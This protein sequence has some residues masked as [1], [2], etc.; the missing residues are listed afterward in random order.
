MSNTR[1]IT[2]EIHSKS[3]E[4]NPLN[5]PVNR[6]FMVYLPPGYFES[7][8]TRYPVIYLLHGYGQDLS[9]L[10]VGSKEYTKKT[11]PFLFRLIAWKVF[12]KRP[13]YEDFDRLI[14]N[15][16]IPPFILVQPECSLKIPDINGALKDNGLPAMKGAFYL[17]SPYTG[18]YSDFIFDELIDYVD[19][20]YRTF[21]D[22]E[23]RALMGGSM[24]G[25][26]TLYG[27]LTHP[28]K[29]SVGVALS[30]LI[31]FLDLLDQKMVV[32]I[33]KLLY[34]KKKA[35]DLGAKEMEDILDTSDLIFCG[36]DR[37]IPSIKRGLNGSIVEMD[38]S[39]KKK[40]LEYDIIEL[41]K[42]SPDPFQNIKLLINCEKTDEYGFPE[43]IEKLDLILTEMGVKHETDIY[44]NKLAE[45]FSPHMVGIG[46][47]LYSGILYCLKNMLFNCRFD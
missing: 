33:Y 10:L 17:N 27:C 2:E 46:I 22:K 16:E 41:V 34:G 32:P 13:K 40:W 20:K 4:G 25:F 12:K 42:K 30:P 26:G 29:F 18:N 9:D 3:L 6:Q 39:S 19:K 36:K 15:K 11:F 44:F 7:E 35:E 1:Y 14:L 31:S 38:E 21:P 45:R 24:G 23:H 5:S 37:L 28:E 47:N 8:E 43:Q